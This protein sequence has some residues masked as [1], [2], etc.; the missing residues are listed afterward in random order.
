M[1][2]LITQDPAD[3]NAGYTDGNSARPAEPGARDRLGYISGWI[4]GEGHRLE[5]AADE[6]EQDP[7]REP[8]PETVA[9]LEPDPDQ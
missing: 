9:D 5:D 3:W 1:P 4:E 6:A 2:V 7:D 8:E